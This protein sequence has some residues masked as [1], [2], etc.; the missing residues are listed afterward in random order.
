MCKPLIPHLVTLP[1]GRSVAVEA[2]TEENARAAAAICFRL[3]RLPPG[4]TVVAGPA[5]QARAFLKELRAA[6]FEIVRLQHAAEDAGLHDCA[7]RLREADAQL[8]SAASLLH[9]SRTDTDLSRALGTFIE[10]EAA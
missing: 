3:Y 10:R 6:D 4:T 7:Q 2:D 1:T 8:L 9:E 5:A